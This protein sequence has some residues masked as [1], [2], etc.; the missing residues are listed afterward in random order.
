MDAGGQLFAVM[1]RDAYQGG[2]ELAASQVLAHVRLRAI[3]YGI[4]GVY[5]SMSGRAALVAADGEV[6]ARSDQDAPAGVLTWSRTSGARDHVDQHEPQIAVLYSRSTTDLRPDCMPGRCSFHALEELDCD[7][8]ETPTVVVSAHGDGAQIAG[9]D[10][11]ALAKQVACFQPD[12]VVL[13][14]CFG[15]STPVLTAL[16]AA[17]D[18]LV[19]AV[20]GFLAGRGL[21]YGQAFYGGASP[22]QRAAAVSTVPPSPLYLASPDLDALARAEAFVGSADGDELRPLLRSWVPTLVAVQ[23]ASGDEVLVPADWRRIGHP[24]DVKAE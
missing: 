8:R 14:V 19:V 2:S 18:A 10:L 11:V 20:P 16:G 9:M 7:Q 6:L 23:L 21:R 15:A 12:L 13:D 17:T 1:A 22:S 5:A 3:E 24:G 4:P